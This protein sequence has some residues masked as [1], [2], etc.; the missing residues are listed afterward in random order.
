M[1]RRSAKK[2]S[3][4]RRNLLR[5]WSLF[6]TMETVAMGSFLIQGEEF[7]KWV[8]PEGKGMWHRDR[9]RAGWDASRKIC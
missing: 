1:R 4:E 6:A 3:F 2:S 9:A 7:K 8:K 5:K